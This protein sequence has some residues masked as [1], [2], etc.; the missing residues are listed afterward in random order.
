MKSDGGRPLPHPHAKHGADWAAREAA[1]P[2]MRRRRL[3]PRGLSSSHH[4]SKSV[5]GSLLSAPTLRAIGRKRKK[6]VLQ[7]N[8]HIKTLPKYPESLQP[9]KTAAAIIHENLSSRHLHLPSACL[10]LCCLFLPMVVSP[11][12]LRD[13]KSKSLPHPSGSLPEYCPPVPVRCCAFFPIAIYN[14]YLSFLL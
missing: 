6:S 7:R 10:L 2:P 4:L 8:P 12:E 11:I 1:H 3:Q 14:L 13:G 5:S 9:E